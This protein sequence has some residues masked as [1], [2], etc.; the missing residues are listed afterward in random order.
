RTE[1]TQELREHDGL[2]EA[3]ARWRQRRRER[4][5]KEP[6]D[7]DDIFNELVKRDPTLATL[8]GIGGRIR[9]GTGPGLTG[10]F[11]GKKFPTYFRLTEDSRKNLQ[12]T[13]PLNATVRVEFETDVDNSYFQRPDDPGELAVHPSMDLVE[14][15]RL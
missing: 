8:L 10:K 1:L 9:T 6:A 7:V 3:N 12:K 11:E 4:A 14:S 5:A 2:K 13:C 15:S